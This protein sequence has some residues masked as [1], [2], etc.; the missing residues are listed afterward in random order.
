MLIAERIKAGDFRLTIPRTEIIFRR[1][2]HAKTILQIVLIVSNLLGLIA[3]AQASS[4]NNSHKPSYTIQRFWSDYSVRED[5]SYEYSLERTVRILTPRGVN[6]AGEYRYSYISSQESVTSVEAW[7][8]QPDGTRI[9]VAESAIR[10]QED[11]AYGGSAKFTDSRD[12]VVIFPDVKVGSVLH[13]RIKT[14]FHTPSFPKQFFTTYRFTNSIP[15]GDV[16]ISISVP[17]SMKLFTEQRGM[18]GSQTAS[19]DGTT[20]FEYQYSNPDASASV[21]N[22]VSLLD[23]APSLQA[24]TFETPVEYGRQYQ[25]YAEPQSRPNDAIRTLADQIT[26][27]LTDNREKV[28]KLYEWVAMNI[29]YVNTVLGNGRLIPHP[30]GEV[31]ADRYGDCKGHVALLE[32]LL[33]AVGIESSPALVNLGDSYQIASIGTVAPFNH[34][35]TYVPE[36]DLFID[37][38]DRFA[39]FGSLA[40]EVMDKPV[41]LTR[42]NRTART[43][44]VIPEQNVA[45]SSVQ[46]RVTEDGTILGKSKTQYTGFREIDSRYARFE[47]SG[48]TNEDQ[49][50]LVLSQFK[51]TGTGK[52]SP[53]DPI[54]IAA[55][56]WIDAV[57]EM[58]APS[59]FPGRG[60]FK[61]PVGLSHA[62]VPTLATDP[63]P[64]RTEPFICKSL[65]A[66]ENYT[67]EFPSNV[68]IE[69]IPEGVR[70]QS[71]AYEYESKFTLNGR[72]LQVDR[73]LTVSYPGSVCAPEEAL[74]LKK[75][76]RVLQRDLRQ[77][78]FY[79]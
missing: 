18:T 77:Q 79:R 72:T 9:Q 39:P 40:F 38:T 5:G 1:R 55:P 21:T 8:I 58:D 74:E 10:T 67:V 51:E 63:Q 54:N 14:N 47:A 68:T 23:R 70:Y 52:I 66:F 41:I 45:R 22:S 59:N 32:A 25:L 75:L 24:S 71:G 2:S 12:K 17:K 60:A 56:Y 19:E 69:E 73:E 34:V 78:V 4:P 76:Q 6:N 27:G 57:F 20:L 49:V 26:H 30:A 16:R 50:N 31:L 7:T 65:K 33:T 64:R 35:M 29:R 53:Q 13:L 46:L 36:L 42:L 48:K 61:L 62:T 44:K 3:T 37:S 28:K 11:P 15:W 43:P